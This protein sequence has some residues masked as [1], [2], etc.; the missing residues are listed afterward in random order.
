MA[1]PLK[2][3]HEPLSYAN[4]QYAPQKP[5]VVRHKFK[6]QRVQTQKRR[7]KKQN[8]FKIL[9]SLIFLG[10]VGYYAMPYLFLNYLEP[11]FLNRIANKHI[12]FDV[13]EIANP[14]R[15]Y[16]TNSNLLGQ[17]LIVEAQ[18]KNKK[19]TQIVTSG[20]NTALKLELTNLM[21]AYPHLKPSIYVW[22][23]SSGKSVEINANKPTASASVIKIPILIELFRQIE[24]E[25][26][27]TI[28]KQVVLEEIYKTSG[29]GDL[30]YGQFNR[31]TN[32]N[33]LAKEMITNSDNSATNIILDYIGG[34]EGLN[35]A[36]REWGLK[37][38]YMGDWLPD[39]A[40]KNKMSAKDLSTM[41]YNLDNPKFLNSQSKEFIK[42]Y[43][44]NVKNR[45]LIQASLP[46]NTTL[47]HKTGDIGKMLGDS[48]IVYS[49]NG[50]K[51]II[52]ILVER[53][54]NDYSAK[55]FIQGATKIIYSNLK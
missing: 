18:V 40:G 28:E 36:F 53:P 13:A 44:G 25:K 51:F 31:R 45:N 11:M 5:N 33:Y 42:E 21:K 30:Q 48:G 12:H 23:Y 46:Q 22:D 54:H 6:P 49:E 20:E 7:V 38:S 24:N 14:S 19:M 2:N 27:L 37:N 16:L 26:D 41:L 15:N 39:L 34:K 47:Y 32:L 9:T 52:S 8:P 29:S 10:L 1:T 4:R 43:M 3:R 17:N 55:D 50:K 35:R